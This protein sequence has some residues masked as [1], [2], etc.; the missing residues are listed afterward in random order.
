MIIL[1]LYVIINRYLY[2]YNMQ[3]ISVIVNNYMPNKF[4]LWYNKKNSLEKGIKFNNLFTMTS[5]LLV[6]F[7]LGNIYI[8]G[9]LYENIDD[10]V[11]VYNHIKKSSMFF[12]I[13]CSSTIEN[14]ILIPTNTVQTSISSDTTHPSSLLPSSSKLT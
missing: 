1:L 10:F 8:S 3:F 11:V 7:I 5:T 2:K 14:S 4:K 9:Y 6:S 12:I 13:G